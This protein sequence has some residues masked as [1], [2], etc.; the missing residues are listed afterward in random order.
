MLYSRIIINQVS[1]RHCRLILS[2]WQVI[3][4]FRMDILSHFEDL[5]HGVKLFLLIGTL[6]LKWEQ[7][8]FAGWIFYG[9]Y[10]LYAIFY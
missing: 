7:I 2:I 6:T 10:Y 4:I 3:Q 9:I 5:S 1:I 8:H